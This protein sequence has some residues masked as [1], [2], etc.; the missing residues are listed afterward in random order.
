MTDHYPKS[1]NEPGCDECETILGPRQAWPGEEGYCPDCHMI[2]A[3]EGGVLLDHRGS[4]DQH[5]GNSKCVGSG[6]YPTEPDENVVDPWEND[7]RP[8][9]KRRN[10]HTPGQSYGG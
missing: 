7:E 1:C 8:G 4:F 2:V 5:F 9:P 10:T 3:C 6:T